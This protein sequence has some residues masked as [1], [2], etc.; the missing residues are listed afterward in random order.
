LSIASSSF[1]TGFPGSLC[2]RQALKAPQSIRLKS[3]WSSRF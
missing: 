1:T 2:S 3:G